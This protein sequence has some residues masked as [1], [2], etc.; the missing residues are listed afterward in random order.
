ME[1]DAALH[2]RRL[3]RDHKQL[4]AIPVPTCELPDGAVI[5][6]AGEAYTSRV[7][8]RFA[9]VSEATRPRQ[10]YLAPTVF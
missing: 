3:D 10:K 6:A 1:I 4:L 8:A 7:A 9:G 5:A 2:E